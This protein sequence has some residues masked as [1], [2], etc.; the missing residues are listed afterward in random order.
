MFNNS[1]YLSANIGIPIFSCRAKSVF[2]TKIPTE[3]SFYECIID[4]EFFFFGK[5]EKYLPI[6]DEERTT[7]RTLLDGSRVIDEPIYKT[8]DDFFITRDKV[9]CEQLVVSQK[10]VDL[11]REEKLN[12]NFYSCKGDLC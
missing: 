8:D 9:F 10:F 2:E 4:D 3:I 7:F 6:I 5:I 12:I 1:D 11:C